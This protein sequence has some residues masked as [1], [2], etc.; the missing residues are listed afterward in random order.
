MTVCVQSYVS[1]CFVSLQEIGTVNTLI[2]LTPY[3]NILYLMFWYLIFWSTSRRPRPWISSAV[4]FVVVWNLKCAVGNYSESQQPL[5]DCIIIQIAGSS[6]LRKK[7]WHWPE[8]DASIVE[9]ATCSCSRFERLALRGR[10]GCYTW[11]EV[12]TEG[13]T[14]KGRR[15]NLW[16]TRGDIFLGNEPGVKGICNHNLCVC[17]NKEADFTWAIS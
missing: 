3:H 13:P 16:T 2:H 8:P 14:W 11:L 15:C 17:D 5:Y 1:L 6:A 4:N 9:S 7:L 12:G 10:E